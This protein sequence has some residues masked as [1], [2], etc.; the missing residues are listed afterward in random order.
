MEQ[1]VGRRSRKGLV[2]VVL[3][4]VLVLDKGALLAVLQ[5]L[6]AVLALVVFRVLLEVA[7]PLPLLLLYRLW[8]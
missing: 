1:V 4:R 2:E 8:Q 5:R 7:W 6:V 3:L